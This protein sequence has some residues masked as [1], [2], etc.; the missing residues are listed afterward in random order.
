M[1]YCIVTHWQAQ[2]LSKRVNEFIADGW[3]PQG[4][5]AYTVT[6]GV[7]ESFAQAMVREV[8]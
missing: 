3:V 7:D 6:L 8:K 4:G 2:E 5:V 1:E